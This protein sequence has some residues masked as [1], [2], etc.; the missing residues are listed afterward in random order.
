MDRKRFRQL[1]ITEQGKLSKEEMHS[2]MEKSIDALSDGNNRGTQNIIIVVQECSELIQELTDCLRG[3]G[4]AVGLLEELADVAIG[5]EY[6]KMIY[7]IDDETL[8]TAIKIKIDE[9]KRKMESGS[10]IC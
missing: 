1:F 7:K 6:I 4:D 10:K 8:D 5:I 9:L 2:I 3:K